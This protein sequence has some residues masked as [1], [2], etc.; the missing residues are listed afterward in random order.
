MDENEFL[1]ME[2]VVKF[3]E[4]IFQT[5]S[6]LN[7][8]EIEQTIKKLENWNK[9]PNFPQHVF[10]ILNTYEC[11]SDQLLFWLLVNLKSL[12]NSL[13]HSN[14]EHNEFLMNLAPVLIGFI[15]NANLLNKDNEVIRD[16]AFYNLTALSCFFFV[17]EDCSIKLTI[18][19]LITT[20]FEPQHYLLIL[21][22][23][24]NE[25]DHNHNYQQ[26]GSQLIREF[27]VG[28][29][30]NSSMSLDWITTCYSL[31]TQLKN[32]ENFEW[33]FDN[34]N[35]ASQM[36]EEAMQQRANNITPPN[37]NIIIKIIG[38][39]TDY[40]ST[41]F[42][43]DNKTDID[44]YNNVYLYSL[45]LSALIRKYINVDEGNIDRLLLL[46]IGVLYTE[47]DF[48][49]HYR[50]KDTLVCVLN[51]LEQVVHLL[52]Q[53]NDLL[54]EL[55]TK[56]SRFSDVF[57]DPDYFSTSD[58]EL[59]EYQEDVYPKVIKALLNDI[60]IMLN[61]NILNEGID[62][63]FN[64]IYYIAEKSIL[65]V[66]NEMKDQGNIL[67]YPFVSYIWSKIF[68][69]RR[70]EAEEIGNFLCMELKNFTEYPYF[71]V[72]FIQK[73]GCSVIFK[74]Y[75]PLFF[76]ILLNGY[77]VR[78]E[79]SQEISRIIYELSLINSDDFDGKDD[80]VKCLVM[81]FKDPYSYDSVNPDSY[82]ISALIYLVNL[83][84]SDY[85]SCYIIKILDELCE[86]LEKDIRNNDINGICAFLRLIIN[87]I[88][89]IS[90]IMGTE[91][92]ADV[93]SYIYEKILQ[94][95]VG[96]IMLSDY[97]V[98][99][100]I[101]GLCLNLLFSLTHYSSL[102]SP[103][104]S[105]E[106]YSLPTKDLLRL[107]C[108]L[109]SDDFALFLSK[110]NFKSK[111]DEKCITEIIHF[112][113]NECECSENAWKMLPSDFILKIL[114]EEMCFI[115]IE[116]I[117]TS[118]NKRIHLYSED[119]QFLIDLCNILTLHLNRVISSDST[120]YIYKL[121][122][123]I[124]LVQLLKSTCNFLEPQ[125]STQI[126]DNIT[127]TSDLVVELKRRIVD[128]T[129]KDEEELCSMCNYI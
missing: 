112:I 21:R 14:E 73:V 103:P 8:D 97:F 37:Y 101:H 114:N 88:H 33:V 106:S 75:H 129:Y 109:N 127:N 42:A 67:I 2:T 71:V 20:Y 39:I 6:Q 63:F 66:I 41:I 110:L 125:I 105:S 38:S 74:E 80:V 47:P 31:T 58:N 98:K 62:V 120:E 25:S 115:N 81:Y 11:F 17:K 23:F 54:F 52:T 18:P 34:F 59:R 79:P 57:N 76:H 53:D 104:D 95:F 82:I 102:I 27:T 29:L 124:A 61:N 77:Y 93:T 69:N 78:C 65:S 123:K 32:F 121:Q 126:I 19:S 51:E 85:R 49:G 108:T 86:K 40:I 26:S 64:G 70:Q 3:V 56:M 48:I 87:V 46:W 89:N 9:Q 84:K 83:D 113:T 30:R 128:T 7:T 28:V 90:T 24:F 50:L 36:F 99:E 10:Q 45:Q 16:Y 117:L 68:E 12:I 4:T 60:L 22:L 44:F 1:D 72:I 118:L 122:V 92:T 5:K 111:E 100:E 96:Q 94:G 91:R 119:T 15:M 35:K 55:L 116:K 13:E 107:L 43:Y